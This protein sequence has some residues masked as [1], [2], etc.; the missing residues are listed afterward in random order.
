VHTQ[1][2]D[3]RYTSVVRFARTGVLRPVALPGV[4][5]D[6]AEIRWDQKASGITA[7]TT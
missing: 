3:G 4:T 2:V 6:V 1:P 7:S 5:I